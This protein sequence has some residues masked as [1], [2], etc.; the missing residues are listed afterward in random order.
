MTKLHS[1]NDCVL[2]KMETLAC[3]SVSTPSSR[4][5]YVADEPEDE[6]IVTRIGSSLCY[7]IPGFDVLSVELCHM[8]IAGNVEGT[9]PIYVI[10]C[11]IKIA[12]TFTLK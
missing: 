12:P 7:I 2:G 10:N 9:G 3:V 4:P 11:S 8:R 1:V 5:S 6:F